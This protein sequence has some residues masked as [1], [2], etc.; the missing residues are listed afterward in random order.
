M[1]N[2][3]KEDDI[4]FKTAYWGFIIFMKIPDYLTRLSELTSIIITLYKWSEGMNCSMWTHVYG[5]YHARCPKIYLI[6][7]TK[8]KV[9]Y[10]IPKP[11]VTKYGPPLHASIPAD[12]CHWLIK[13]HLLHIRHRICLLVVPRGFLRLKS[14]HHVPYPPVQK[15]I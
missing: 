14:E 1:L 6:K 4:F 3:C 13:W 9:R 5:L 2:V 8:N 11:V 12:Q 7:K 15:K 10:Y